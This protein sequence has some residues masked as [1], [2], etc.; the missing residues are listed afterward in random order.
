MLYAK[1]LKIA[2][3]T[4]VLHCIF[5]NCVGNIDST[6]VFILG[7]PYTFIA[8]MWMFTGWSYGF[9]LIE[10]LGFGC[11]V[12]LFYP[13]GMLLEDVVYRKK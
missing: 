6:F 11:M 1:P 2:F 9:I 10:L 5:G 12:F 7:L 4:A 13:V 8:K 3:F